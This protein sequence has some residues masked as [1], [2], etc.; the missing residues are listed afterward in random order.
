MTNFDVSLNARNSNPAML[1]PEFQQTGVPAQQ[2]S[3]SFSEALSGTWSR[4]ESDLANMQ[5]VQQGSIGQQFSLEFAGG[6]QNSATPTTNFNLSPAAVEGSV[7]NPATTAASAATTTAASAAT[8]A[9][10]PAGNIAPAT[11]GTVGSTT[12]SD[13]G[14]VSAA[15]AATNGVEDQAYDDAYWAQQPPAVQQLRD[16]NYDQRVQVGSQLAAEGY[17]IDV[18]IMIW[19]WDPAKVTATREAA[20]YTWV[21]SALQANVTAAPGITAPGL[22]PYDPNNPP[23][24]SIAVS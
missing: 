6:R 22:T 18:P 16:M 19:G 12:S 4:L 17:T 3:T 24:G 14:V 21:P 5:S 10:L 15:Q 23:A 1:V 2:F 9:S 7:S 20:G 13:T 11:A 8:T